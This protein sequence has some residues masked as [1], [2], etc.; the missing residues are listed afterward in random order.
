MFQIALML[1]VALAMFWWLHIEVATVGIIVIAFLIAAK[2]RDA[3][4]RGRRLML[5]RE[6][7]E[8]AEEEARRIRNR[9]ATFIYAM[10]IGL[11]VAGPVHGDS[12]AYMHHPGGDMGGD[13]G[14]GFDGGGFD[15]G[16]GGDAGGGGL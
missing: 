7:E 8:D 10:W 16:G 4:N 13:L 3:A 9:D 6:D 12:S 11:T 5:A 15:G 1:A 14:G 2:L